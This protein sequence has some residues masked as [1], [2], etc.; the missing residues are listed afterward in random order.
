MGVQAGARRRTIETEGYGR[1]EAAGHLMAAEGGG[2]GTRGLAPGSSQR[3][4]LPK[5]GM[6]WNKFL[7]GRIE[8]EYSKKGPFSSQNILMEFDAPENLTKKSLGS[9]KTGFTDV[10]KIYWSNCTQ[11]FHRDSLTGLLVCLIHSHLIITYLDFSSLNFYVLI[12][13]QVF[14]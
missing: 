4:R 8:D 10:D 2:P 14:T 6:V 9:R 3:R 1:A 7:T 5:S 12:L 11:V 13:T